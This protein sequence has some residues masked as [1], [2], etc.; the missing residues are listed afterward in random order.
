MIKISTKTRYGLRALM[1]L[2][3]QSSGEPVNLLNIA[4]KQKLSLKYLESIFNLLKN[5]NVIRSVR[6]PSGGYL[7]SRKPEDL[8]LYDIFTAINGP[9][10]ITDCIIDPAICGNSSNCHATV[11]W[12][13]L[14]QNIKAFFKSKTLKDI[15]NAK[16]CVK[17]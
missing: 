8:S 3:K 10:K 13:E 1:E 15:M 5:N 14:Q 17:V 7:L 9:L 11:I 12:N 2:V 4:R 16:R 6:G